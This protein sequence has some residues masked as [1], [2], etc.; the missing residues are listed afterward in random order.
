MFG[1]IISSTVATWLPLKTYYII[2]L[3]MVLFASVFSAFA[4]AG[5]F[6]IIGAFPPKYIQAFV[7]GH[8]IAGVVVVSFNIVSFLITRD[9]SNGKF[10]LLFFGLG[11][12]A[13]VLS[14]VFT[15]IQARSAFYQH[16]LR[17]G[18][19]IITRKESASVSVGSRQSSYWSLFQ[20]TWDLIAALFVDVVV[21]LILFPNLVLMTK[22]THM[23]QADTSVSLYGSIFTQTA[24]LIMSVAG[25]L[26]KLLPSIEFF[27]IRQA[28]FLFLASLRLIFVP[29]VLLGNIV[30]PERTVIY[31][32]IL[33]SDVLYFIVISFI[34]FT[35]GYLGTLCMMWAPSRVKAQ[36]RAKAATL[37]IFALAVGLLVGSYLSLL[38][39]YLFVRLATLPVQLKL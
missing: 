34:G 21:G 17:L 36:D 5:F 9:A 2:L 18:S 25:L 30:I 10:A 38:V 16:Y 4:E 24:L 15:Q 31:E 3:T 8:G 39:R 13:M 20:K 12:A 32:R 19:D 33:A 11:L 22:S 29:L 35:G 7:F 37:I 1:I 26:G 23:S 28:P 27:A 14:F 6:A